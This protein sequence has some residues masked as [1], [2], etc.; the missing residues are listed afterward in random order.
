M[1]NGETSVL[2]APELGGRILQYSYRGH[3]FLYVNSSLAG[4][5]YSAKPQDIGTWQWK[6]YGGDK[7]WPA[8]QGWNGKQE[9]PGPDKMIEDQ[10]PFVANILESSG[11]SVRVDL[12]GPRMENYSG[13]QF[14]RS[15][16]LE[17]GHSRLNITSTMKNVSEELKNWSLWAVT[18]L[19]A[20][21]NVGRARQGLQVIAPL[22]PASCFPKGFH[23]LFGQ[24]NHPGFKV[25]PDR[26]LF[27]ADY[28]DMVGK[29]GLDTNAGWAALVDK[30]AN[31]SFV[32]RFA[33]NAAAT[34]PDRTSFTVWFNAKGSIV[35]AG[36][37]FTL[38]ENPEKTPRYLEMEILSPLVRLLPG[39]S[40]SFATSWQ[41]ISGGLSEVLLLCGR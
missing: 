2:I 19:R 5:V 26:G 17:D 31:L 32:Q 18:Q 20:S 27:I 8:P 13:L 41:A 30:E 24:A 10:V 11:P 25:D 39:E 35:V 4:Q 1:R 36:E 12:E 15:L 3:E 33:Y 21:D 16:V 23:I 29:A 28:C 38:E 22:N 14:T 34:Y 37:T 9:W 40:Y 7:V 6:N